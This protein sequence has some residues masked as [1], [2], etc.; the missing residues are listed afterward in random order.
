MSATTPVNIN[1]SRETIEDFKLSCSFLFIALDFCGFF[2][3][4]ITPLFSVVFLR[5]RLVLAKQSAGASAGT[6]S[7]TPHGVTAFTLADHK[8]LAFLFITIDCKGSL[9][10]LCCPADPFSLEEG[11]STFH[12]ELLVLVDFNAIF[13]LLWTGGCIYKGLEGMP[14]RA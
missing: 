11:C 4:V 3:G 6:P 12:D 9:R 8:Q 10:S 14:I 7:G 5:F 13:K 2:T 1:G